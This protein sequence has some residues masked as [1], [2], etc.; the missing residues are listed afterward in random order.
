MS[1]THLKHC[2]VVLVTLLSAFDGMGQIRAI[3]INPISAAFGTASVSFEHVRDKQFSWHVTATY[4]PELKGPDLIFSPSEEGW[5]LTGSKTQ[6]WGAQIAHRWYT[7]KGRSQP[8]KPYF[9]FFVQHQ[10][11]NAEANYASDGNTYQL[12]G[13]W[14][15]T[16][17]GLQYGI[18]WI[19]RDSFSVDL[20]LI[21][22]GLAFGKVDGT[23]RTTG[24]EPN[25]GLWEEN[26]GRI[27]LIGQRILMRGSETPYS[28]EESYTTI[29]LHTALRV[30]FL[31]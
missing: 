22:F 27:P 31:F 16:T 4:R 1:A 11:W 8:T 6:L 14:S 10:Q 2:I 20:T 5:T 29:G 9:A 25:I 13:D 7:R 15:Q 21:G 30:G 26:L 23:G 24:D 12:S 19:F 3:K 28:F 17:S 18:N